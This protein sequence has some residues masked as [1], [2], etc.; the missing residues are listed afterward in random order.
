[1]DITTSYKFIWQQRTNS[2]QQSIPL[3][4]S[5]STQAPPCP[6]AIK[7]TVKKIE[8]KSGV[9][10]ASFLLRLFI[11]FILA[12]IG[13]SA[14]FLLVF[15]MPARAIGGILIIVTPFLAF[16]VTIGAWV[17]QG[18]QKFRVERYLMA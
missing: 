8:E 6:L 17:V 7:E 15:Y 3:S 11:L 16:V 4:N 2:F 12:V 5:A 10:R 9:K 14:G 13:N 1:M 18:S